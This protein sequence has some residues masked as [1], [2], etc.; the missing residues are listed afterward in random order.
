MFEDKFEFQCQLFELFC[1]SFGY[2]CSQLSYDL[3]DDV[4]K[5][6]QYASLWGDFVTIRVKLFENELKSLFV[7]KLHVG[8][9]DIIFFYSYL[10]QYR[11]QCVKFAMFDGENGE[12]I[13]KH[14]ELKGDKENNKHG[15]CKEMHPILFYYLIWNG[16]LC[17]FVDGELDS[18]LGNKFA[19]SS[20]KKFAITKKQVIECIR[21]WF[22]VQCAR[23]NIFGKF[24]MPHY[25]DEIY[26]KSAI[27]RCKI[28]LFGN[29]LSHLVRLF[30]YCMQDIDNIDC[31]FEAYE[32]TSTGIS[33][34][35]VN[36]LSFAMFDALYY[37]GLKMNYK[38][39]NSLQFA[40]LIALFKFLYNFSIY[41][42]CIPHRNGESLALSQYLNFK[43]TLYAGSDVFGKLD[44]INN[45]KDDAIVEPT[46]KHFQFRAEF[47]FCDGTLLHY[48]A[49]RNQ[50]NL[51]SILIKEGFDYNKYNLFSDSERM[52]PMDIAKYLKNGKIIA[53]FERV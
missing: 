38:R 53:L 31:Y 39:Q 34:F 43:D 24:I 2:S 5:S 23:T 21:D 11:T 25:D 45:G 41:V 52:T 16:L 18:H 28:A 13:I 30:E 32:N 4:N 50:F 42:S 12:K 7:N 37:Y 3:F 6:S 29:D 35:I 26:N 15:F 8:N 40:E 33:L 51:C 9:D 46:L 48:A 1:Q 22:I 19:N 44:F 49:R 14:F 20:G 36:R 27:E 47:E 10:E 17:L